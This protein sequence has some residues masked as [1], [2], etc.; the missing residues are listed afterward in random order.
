MLYII[1]VVIINLLD[2]SDPL[3]AQATG[4]LL[5]HF[6]HTFL[7]D[8]QLSTIKAVL[9]KKNTVVVQPTG[10]GKSICFQLPPL[11]TGKMTVVITPT[12]SLMND[13]TSKLQERGIQATFLGSSQVDKEVEQKTRKGMFQIIYTTPE[14]FFDNR[15][16]PSKLFNDLISIGQIGLIAFDEVHLVHCWKSFRYANQE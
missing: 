6:G 16:S 4:L 12:I 3:Q 15:G 11:I 8:W 7:K 9:E 5:K 1:I 2:D 13:Q 10:S 14:K